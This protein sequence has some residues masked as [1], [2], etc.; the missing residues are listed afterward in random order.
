MD[1]PPGGFEIVE[2]LQDARATKLFALLCGFL[3]VTLAVFSLTAAFRRSQAKREPSTAANAADLPAQRL[4]DHPQ[5]EWKTMEGASWES[6]SATL[7]FPDG[8][9]FALA[10][11]ASSDYQINLLIP[12]T[13]LGDGRA[14]CLVRYGGPGEFYAVSLDRS[15]MLDLEARGPQGQLDRLA[16]ARLDQPLGSWTALRLDVQG[17][18]LRAWLD[19]Q[20]LID[21]QGLQTTSGDQIAF[22]VRSTRPIALSLSVE[23]LEP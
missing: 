2:I 9:G 15:G 6:G 3:V 20:L 14:T 12:V 23:G 8:V 10:E 17:E 16:R 1:D 18:R 11:V 21:Y 22:S 5:F 4:T 7:R 19:G 13:G